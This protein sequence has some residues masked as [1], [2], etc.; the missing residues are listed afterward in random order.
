MTCT[1]PCLGESPSNASA[2]GLDAYC[3]SDGTLYGLSTRNA[4][5]WLGSPHESDAAIEAAFEEWISGHEAE[6]GLDSGLEPGDLELQRAPDFRSTAGPLHLFR[7]AQSHRGFPVLAPDGMVTLVYGPQGAISLSGAIID[8]RTRYANEDV[9]ASA[10]QAEQSML[11]HA[12]AHSA[13]EAGELEVVHASRVAVPA[14]RAIAWTGIVRHK[15]GPMLARVVVDAGPSS[16]APVL[17]LWDYRELAAAG[18][19]NTQQV[20]VHTVDPAGVPDVLAYSDEDALTTGAPLLGSV[21]DASLEIQLATEQVVVLDL[22]GESGHAVDVFGM[23]VTSPTGDFP[24]AGGTELAAQVAYHLFQSWYAFIDG[25]LTEPVFGSKRWDSATHLYSGG[26]TTSDAPPGTFTPRV[27]AFVNSSAEDCPVQGVACTRAAGYAA[28]PV[29]MA[30]PELLHIPAGATQPEALG[31]VTL[32]GEGIEVVTFA[33][34]FGHVIDLF[35]GAGIT[36]DLAPACM[37]ACPLECIEDTTDE[38]PPLS[39]SI[40]QLFALSFLLQAFDGVTFDFCS[41][42]DLVAVNGTKPWTPGGCVPAG[43]DIS[44]FERSDA[45]DKPS[46]YCDKPEE[47]GVGRHCCFD[48]EDLA[49][50]TLIVPEECPVGATGPSGGSGTGTARAR[51][52]GLCATTPG[53]KTNSLYQAYW[54]LLNGQRCE[55]KPPFACVSVEWAPGVAPLDAATDALLYALRVNALTYEQLFDSMAT[56]VSCTYGPAAYDDFNAVACAH[57]IRDC[58]EPAPMICQTCGNGVREGNEGCDGTDWLLTHCDDLPLYTDG[59]LTCDQNACVLDPSQCMMQ[60]LDTTDGTMPLDA[61]SSSTSAKET[62]TAGADGD[63]AED[64]CRCRTDTDERWLLPMLLFSLLG[65]MRR[66]RNAPKE[67][68]LMRFPMESML[69]VISLSTA[70]HCAQ[71]VETDTELSSSSISDMSSGVSSFTSETSESSTGE[72]FDASQW[73][74]VYHYENPFLPFG[75]LVDPL[76]TDRALANFEIFADSRATMF[77]DNCSFDQPIVINYVWEPDEDGWLRLLPGEG[78]SS[79]R[80]QTTENVESLRVQRT[81]PA[82]M[83]RPQLVFEFDGIHDGFAPYYPGESCWVVRCT[84]PNVM[85]V[86]YCE[87][88]EPSPCP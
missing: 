36:A 50:C 75:E 53:Y 4:V 72:P 8:G 45:C 48:D 80:Y 83:C 10:A 54:Q 7:F 16:T 29:T 78:E 38:A 19:A 57:G 13:G 3:H 66:R 61:S 52:T 35:A 51:P 17:P 77:Y 34:E 47:P 1:L 82:G 40:A 20:Q 79:L 86:G 68:C 81:E 88:E 65:A 30:F 85:Q 64:G 76:G 67:E 73:V 49:D 46:A 59:T 43:E 27:L 42:V 12:R 15:G 62:D 44:S 37:G 2:C 25:H 11:W 39:E 14:A 18:L 71:A 28:G 5:L 24:A 9:Q 70:C 31:L 26:S 23:R 56:Y 6:L 22:Q 69:V 33:H 74:D 21:D 55:P 84:V 63:Q 60:G 58:A 87:G 41:I 32:P